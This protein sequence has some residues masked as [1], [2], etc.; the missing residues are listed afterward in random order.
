[1]WLSYRVSIG[2]GKRGNRLSVREVENIRSSC[3][4]GDRDESRD[5]RDEISILVCL[6]SLQL[7]M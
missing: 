6:V 7:S 4:V 2:L 5:E 1:M 3:I